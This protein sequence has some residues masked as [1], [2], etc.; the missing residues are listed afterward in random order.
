M[1]LHER[2][3]SWTALAAAALLSISAW[4]CQ[5]GDAHEN[6][7]T[8]TA[9]ADSTA[10]DSLATAGTEA[11][12][13]GADSKKSWKDRMFGHKDKE[14]EKDP[15]VPVEVAT[16]TLRDVPAYLTS[17]ATLEPD[18]EADVLSKAAG[19][20]VAVRVE[21]GDWVR[22]GDVLATLD[23]APQAAALE[24]VSAR[25]HGLQLEL[26]RKKAL[27]DQ[28]LASD[29]DLEQAETEFAQ[30]EAQRKKVEL[31]LSYT[32]IRAPFA[33]RVTKRMIDVGQNVVVGGNLFTV[34]DSDPLLA[35]IYL[36]EREVTRLAPDQPVRIQSDADPSI[37]LTGNVVLIAPVVDTRTGTVKVTCQVE[38]ESGKLRPGSFVRVKVETGVHESVASIPKRALVPEGADTYVFRAEADSVMKVPIEVG[39]DADDIVEVL[40]GL[41]VGDRVVSVGHGALRNGSHIRE[42][43]AHAAADS[44]TAD[45][46]L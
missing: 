45:G 6:D 2:F 44:T 35:R 32:T 17:T 1:H 37:E 36:P 7:Q 29:K 41:E 3:R 20:I 11:G 16:V 39:L 4:A 40:D 5:N 22:A 31:E 10:A 13:E 28:H 25:V 46:S 12:P 26:D 18:K 33:G 27:H 23:G 21:E 9:A 42:L 24:E 30:A 8:S 15:P 19:Q 34:V 38:G 14:E 43:T